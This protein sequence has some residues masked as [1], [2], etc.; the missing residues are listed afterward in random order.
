MMG[1]G[2]L[3][4]KERDIQSGGKKEKGGEFRRK[5]K[6]GVIRSGQEGMVEHRGREGILCYTGKG[7]VCRR[8][9]LYFLG[10]HG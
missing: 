1:G 3:P 9:P 8:R 2:V 10:K 6:K 5:K 4:R 7:N